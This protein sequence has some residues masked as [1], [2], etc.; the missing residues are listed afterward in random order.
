VKG[1]SPHCCT[2]RTVPL[3]SGT[4]SRER[5]EQDSLQSPMPRGGTRKDE[6]G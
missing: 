1:K 3:L 5:S 6:N 2:G 4:V